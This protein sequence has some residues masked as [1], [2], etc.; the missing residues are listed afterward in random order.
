V[1]FEYAC[2]ISY[3]HSDKEKTVKFIEQF[4][5]ALENS[6]DQRL[7][8]GVYIDRDR[9]KAGYKF[10]IA[11]AGALRQSVCMVAILSP[12]Y[13][14]SDYCRREYAAMERIEAKRRA[15]LGIPPAEKGLVIPLLV[16]GTEEEVPQAIRE[17]LHYVS[18]PFGL[19]NLRSEIKYDPNLFPIVEKIGDLI[20]EH[21]RSFA[22]GNH[23]QSAVD[24]C[25]EIDLPALTEIATWQ[26]PGASQQP[27]PSRTSS[28]GR[29]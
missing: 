10:N 11:I 18:M 22:D 12:G 14:D 17:N 28:E 8:Q 20:C 5:D 1:T 2:F 27:L 26:Q 7:Q 16:W 19:T 23:C 25:A 29:P 21:H 13:Y 15:D 4:V 6:L 3:R 24:C 9:L